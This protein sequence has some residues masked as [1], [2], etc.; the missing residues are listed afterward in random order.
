[1]AQRVGR[2]AWQ[3]LLLAH[4]LTGPLHCRGIQT[5]IL[6]NRNQKASQ[7]RNEKWTTGMVAG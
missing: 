5:P 7:K 3:T 2:H 4:A 1:M 6:V